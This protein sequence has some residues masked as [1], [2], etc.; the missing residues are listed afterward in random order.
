MKELLLTRRQKVN[1]EI[2]DKDQEIERW[3][4]NH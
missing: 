4:D 2:K 1:I 3:K